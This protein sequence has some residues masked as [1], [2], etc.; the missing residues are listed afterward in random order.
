MFCGLHSY[1]DFLVNS[2]FQYKK[3]RK[4]I[5]LKNTKHRNKNLGSTTVFKKRNKKQ[6]QQKKSICK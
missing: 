1:F 2:D 5:L 3:Q 6:Q 4:Q